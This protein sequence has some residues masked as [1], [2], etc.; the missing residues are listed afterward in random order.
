MNHSNLQDIIVIGLGELGSVFAR[1]ALK[2]GYRVTPVLRH[3]DTDALASHTNPVA[4]IV[5]VGEQ[6]LSSTLANLPNAW[7]DKLVLIQ[8]ELL[9]KDFQTLTPEA[10]VISVWF[11]KKKGM[12]SKVVQSSP[13][14][15]QQAQL[16]I[17]LLASLDLPA[18]A[19][20]SAA[21]LEYQLALKNVYILSTNIAGLVVGGDV[22]ELA[23]THRDLLSAVV[24]DVMALQQA[25]INQTLDVDQVMNDL[26]QAFK[27]DPDHKCM[28]RSAP[29]R[30]AR[31]LKQGQSLGLELTTLNKIAAQTQA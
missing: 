10:T 18:Y 3:T 29:A 23:Q 6:D 19:L 14:Y 5:C 20:A 31:A 27:G 15:G 24:T 13:V 11:E 28:G 1:G 26:L 8:N 16:I 25:Q 7:H 21:E 12:D 22:N 9:P 2:Q 30:L 4:V 17:E